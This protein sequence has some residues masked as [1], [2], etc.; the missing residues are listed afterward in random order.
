MYETDGSLIFY[1]FYTFAA[2]CPPISLSPH[3]LVLSSHFTPSIS[4]F[5]HCSR[6]P[7]EVLCHLILLYAC[8]LYSAYAL[9]VSRPSNVMWHQYIPTKLYYCL[10]HLELWELWYVCIVYPLPQWFL[11]V[12]RFVLGYVSLDKLSVQCSSM[13]WYIVI[14]N[15]ALDNILWSDSCGLDIY[16][17]YFL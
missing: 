4:M 3:P 1:V 7:Q 10:V 5:L 13:G 15:L 9:N 2:P 14:C 12:W 6:A 17:W 8:Q 11:V 16:C